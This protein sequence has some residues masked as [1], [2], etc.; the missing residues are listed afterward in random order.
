MPELSYPVRFECANCERETI[1]EESAVRTLHTNPWG[2]NAVEIV[3][4][5]RG[6]VR[7]DIRGL[8][9]CPKCTGGTE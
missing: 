8:L 2:I 7:D 5:K 4:Q 3:L 6:W 1:V 9:F